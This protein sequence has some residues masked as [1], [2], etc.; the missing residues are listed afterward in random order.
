M[1]NIWIVAAAVAIFGCAGNGD[2]AGDTPSDTGETGA[3]MVTGDGV[4]GGALYDSWWSVTKADAPTSDHPL[5]ASRPDTASNTRTGADTWRCKECH[6]WDYEGVEGAYG[7]GSHKT[8]IVGVRQ[9]SMTPAQIVALLEDP[10]GHDYGSV[11]SDQE[12]ANLAIFVTQW[13]VDTGDYIDSSGLF[14]GKVDPGGVTYMAAC[15]TCHGPDG[16][17]TPPGAGDGFEDFAGLIANENPWEFLHKV[18]FGQPGTV[19][20]AQATLLDPEELTDLGAFAQ[21][22]PKS[23]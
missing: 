2:T 11:L 4:R 16:L 1:W 20:P 23:Q 5:W 9:T 6:G 15:S 13:T 22:L 7:E 21:T 3:D 17:A 18:R 14:T 10:A 19:M 8:G 12:L